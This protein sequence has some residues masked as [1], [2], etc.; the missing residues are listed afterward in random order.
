MGFDPQKLKFDAHGVPYLKATEIEAI[1]YELLEKYCPQVL[2]TATLT[3]VL[4]IIEELKE[5]T[6]LQSAIEDLGN[7]EGKKVLGKVSFKRRTLF[8]DKSLLEERKIQF[9][10]TAAH[11]IGHWVL[12]RYK[13]LKLE[14]QKLNTEELIDDESSICRLE[15]RT[16]KEWL[17]RQANVFAASLIMPRNTFHDELVR[18]QKEIGILRNFGI[19]FINDE[20]YNRKDRM[21]ILAMLSDKFQVSKQ[22][23]EVR[24]NTLKL[25][26][27]EGK[28]AGKSIAE[29]LKNTLS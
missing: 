19:V 5:K 3:P 11:E 8:L 23:I 29:I 21:M 7:I 12:H 18:S 26:V 22:S 24:L 28:K 16:P 20:N 13:Q 25:V 1:A 14:N 27:D 17:E 15:Q 6:K 2:T 10:F 4:D 9:R